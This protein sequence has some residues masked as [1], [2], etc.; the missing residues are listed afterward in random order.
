MSSAAGFSSSYFSTL[1]R[2]ETGKNFLEYLM[3]VRIE[4]AKTL[5]RESR[6]T[7]EAVAKAVGVND[8][9]RFS[10]TFKKTT[11]SSP[12]EYRNLYS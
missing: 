12:K 8:Y 11:G 1:F 10:K 2:K 7:I 9:K 5:L 4:E 6:M 3:D